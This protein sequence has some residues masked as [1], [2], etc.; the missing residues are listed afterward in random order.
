MEIQK[1]LIC[2]V[3]VLF[4]V[5]LCGWIQGNKFDRNYCNRQVYPGDAVDNIFLLNFLINFYALVKKHVVSPGILF[6][7]RLEIAI[8]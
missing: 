2:L 1:E 6:L 8:F 4:W 7:T 3:L 5:H